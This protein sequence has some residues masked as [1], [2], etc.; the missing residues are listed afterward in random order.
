[1]I[2]TTELDR[3]SS[4][5][6]TAAAIWVAVV[7]VI[8]YMFLP[9]IIG[10]LV[11]DLGFSNSETGFIG[12]AEAGGMAL[13]NALAAL[14]LRR[15]NWRL[16][17]VLAG[18]IMAIANG[19]STVVDTFIAM[20]FVRLVDGFAG[21]VLIALGVACLSDNRN[22]NRVFGYFIAS[23]MIFASIGFYFLPTIQLS[24]GVDGIFYAL[25]LISITGI[26]VAPFHPDKGLIRPKLSFDVS[27]L[28]MKPVVIFT[29]ALFAAL[30]FFMS[31]G[32]LWAFVERLGRA[33][34]LEPGDIGLALMIS[35]AFG[36]L[37]ALG[38][39]HVARKF[40]LRN[41]F[42]IV[43]A[44]E[45]L[46]IVMLYGTLPIQ[47]YFVALCLFIMFWSMGLPLML[48]QC[49][50]LDVSGKLVVLLYAVGKLGYTLGPAIMGMLIIEDNYT[51][52]ISLALLLCSMGLIINVRLAHSPRS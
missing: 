29:V 39:D 51:Y 19:I 7:G 21:G 14:F 45:V 32:G 5:V 11:D 25:V 50:G 9:L 20:F 46:C 33:S 12:A 24:F 13:A 28:A 18:T 22:A 17:I 16:I 15:V 41:A 1:L 52:V 2:D 27:G 30:L 42:I 31:Q 36:I 34:Q 48:T 26:L 40:G 37:G 4:P 6:A 35:S 23:E 3:V 44:G 49:N 43:L 8:A 47:Q 10:G 38:A